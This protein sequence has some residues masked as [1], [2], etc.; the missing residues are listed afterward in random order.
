MRYICSGTTGIDKL[1]AVEELRNFKLDSGDKINIRIISLEEL[2]KE[3]GGFDDIT[4]FLNSYNWQAQKNAWENAFTQMLED[5]NKNEA[6]LIILCTHLIYFRNSRF[7]SPLN[8][9]LIEKFNPDGFITIID[10]VYL[11]RKRIQ[12]RS[13]I[14]AFKTE[15]RLRDLFAWRSIETNITDILCSHLSNER[16]ISNYILSVKH[17]ITTLNDLIFDSDNLKVYIAH[18][19]TSTRDVPELVEEIEDFKSELHK[20]FITFDPTTIDERLLS[21]SLQ[22]QY[23]EWSKMRKGELAESVVQINI[24]K[25]W[26]IGHH[27]LLCSNIDDLFPIEIPADEVVEVIQDID[28]QIQNRDY[29]LVSQSDA[30]VAFRPYLGGKLSTGVFSE[31]QY[32]RDVAFKPCHMYFP[33]CDGDQETTPFKGRGSSY[34]TTEELLKN[35]M[36][37]RDER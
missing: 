24:D 4:L 30:I 21:I 18:P 34:P 33:E 11:L 35:L 20:E 22:D 3:R 13:E 2:L 25:R 6:D 27:P 26:P 8:I 10:D 15:L 29:R 5:I 28:N 9:S 19:I 31:T 16:R 14:S 32:A 36:R 37:L 23:P 7:L 12:K 17:P 1:E